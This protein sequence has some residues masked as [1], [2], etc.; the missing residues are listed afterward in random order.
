VNFGSGESPP[1]PPLPSAVLGVGVCRRVDSAKLAAIARQM[2]GLV[3]GDGIGGLEANRWTTP[4]RFVLDL[5][6]TST[7][8]A[9]FP[10]NVIC[11]GVVC[12]L[13]PAS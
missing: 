12:L 13:L 11:G 7:P 3:E 5:V 6:C 4:G 2:R 9:Q 10:E 8:S 1:Y